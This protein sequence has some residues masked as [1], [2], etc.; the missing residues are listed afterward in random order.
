[1]SKDKKLKTPKTQKLAEAA[2]NQKNI[3]PVDNMCF[4]VRNDYAFKKLFGR[5][6]NIIILQD[7][8]SVVLELDKD[9]FKN[10]VIENPAVGSLLCQYPYLRRGISADRRTS[11]D[12][13]GNECKNFSAVFG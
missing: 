2:E 7:F 6:E 5:P 12:L 1:M 8:L 11:F 10:I 9:A 4:T 3:E 13:S